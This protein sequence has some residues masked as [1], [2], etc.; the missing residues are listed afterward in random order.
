M[1]IDCDIHVGYETLQDLIPH[2][3]GATAELV[4]QSGTNGLGMPSYPWY[5]PSG[6]LRGDAYD[7]DAATRGGQLVGQTLE[8]VR[9]MV[10][11]PFDVTF[12]I[13]TPDEA[14]AFAILPNGR[15]GAALCRGYN[16][17][18]IAEWLEREPR[19]RGLLVVTPQYPEAAAAEIRRLGER[20]EI[21]GVFLPGAA[22][23]PYGNPV[24]DPIWLACD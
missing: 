12:G 13:L 4:E 11:D 5:H 17:W 15:L 10:L 6:W 19:L 20:Q 2:L 18:L 9:A 1:L 22:R 8:R 16:D 7:R 23:I 21:A 14:A 24:H 3:D